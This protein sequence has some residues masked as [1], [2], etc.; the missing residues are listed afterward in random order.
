M[1]SLAQETK[2]MD[3]L[4]VLPRPFP[5][6]ELMESNLET[7]FRMFP[8]RK[9]NYLKYKAARRSQVLDYMPIRLDVENV[10]RCNFRCTMCQVSDWPKSKRAEDMS[11]EEYRALVEGQY[12]LIEIKLQGMGE[13][14]LGTS[15][16]D[17]IEYAR[18]K[19][20]W[21]RSTTNGSLLHV[22]ENY[23]RLIDADI[24]EV[25]VSLDGA[26]SGTYERIRRGGRFG[27]V[28]E[29]SA[30]L[31]RYCHD[32]GRMRTRMWTVVQKENFHEI[33]QF[34]ALAS[35]LGF[36]RLTLSLDLNDWGQEEWKR[37]NDRVDIHHR[38][39]LEMAEHLVQ[40]GKALDVNVTFWFIDEKFDASDPRTVCP[41]P[42]ERA[43]ISSDMRVVPCCMM[44]NP[45]VFDLGDAHHLAEVWRNGR[46]T[47]FR[48]MHL[49]GAIPDACRSC[50][51]IG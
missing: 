17:M 13:P 32:V 7:G 45:E 39:D 19:Y 15:Y 46:M 22:D 50:Y 20:I 9:E 42:F 26:T 44:A 10:S 31:N 29:N 27:R 38:F 35:D 34:P 21:V 28:A 49:D 4:D 43:Y 5:D 51:G 47:H 12:G 37:V 30:L 48:K 16:F 1:S 11:L 33:E 2:G 18:A 3:R 25:H 40:S 23:K 41:W 36:D 6:P 24:C 14:L 8:E